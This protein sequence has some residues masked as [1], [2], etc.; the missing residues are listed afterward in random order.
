MTSQY[1]AF[2]LTVAAF[3]ISIT[4][5]HRYKK[6]V[7]NELTDYGMLQ[8]SWLWQF[9]FILFPIILLWGFE[10]GYIISGGSGPSDFLSITWFFVF[11]F[12]YFFS[13][14]AYRNPNLFDNV[15]KNIQKEISAEIENKEKHP[16]TIENSERITSE[17][18][19]HQFYLNEEL[20]VHS[21]AKEINMS[22]R[23]ISSC[24]NSRIGYNFNEWVNNYRVEKALQII[25]SDEKNMLSIEGIGSDSG[26]KSR[27]AMYAAFKKKLGHSPGFYRNN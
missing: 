8:I 5:T 9:I 15:S 10:L 7:Q 27:S 22:S 6:L 1:C 16:C 19:K 17:M 2:I 25:K 26:F 23:L 14:K 24:I 3:I 18:E 11:I 4:E 12:L 20:T 13:F 21:F